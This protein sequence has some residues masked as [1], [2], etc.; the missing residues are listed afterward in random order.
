MSSSDESE[1]E[2]LGLK[3]VTSV[4]KVD[5]TFKTVPENKKF[6]FEIVSGENR[7]RYMYKL[8]ANSP[9]PYTAILEGYLFL[10]YLSIGLF[11][12]LRF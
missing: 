1:C 9:L 10:F 4:K 7:V 6:K 3:R 11:S 5:P 8:K 2:G 12:I